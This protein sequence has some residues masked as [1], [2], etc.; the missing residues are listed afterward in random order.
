MNKYYSFDQISCITNED[1]Y[2]M[3]YDVSAEHN[4]I[5]L[6]SALLCS[7]DTY[8]DLMDK[9]NAHNTILFL[10]AMPTELGTGDVASNFRFKHDINKNNLVTERWLNVFREYKKNKNKNPVVITTVGRED[11]YM[12][13]KLLDDGTVNIVNNKNDDYIFQ[14]ETE[15]IKKFLNVFSITSEH[16]KKMRISSAG[17]RYNTYMADMI[18]FMNI[19][20]YKY[21]QDMFYKS[22]MESYIVTP[23]CKIKKSGYYNGKLEPM[24]QPLVING[25]EWIPNEGFNYLYFRY[26]EGNTETQQIFYKLK[27]GIMN[28]VYYQIFQALMPEENGTKE[29]IRNYL[30]GIVYNRLSDFWVNDIDDSFTILMLINAY[31]YC[32]LNDNDTLILERFEN[33]AEPWFKEM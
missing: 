15:I 5:E 10:P 13:F 16:M 21:H 1:F 28:I 14:E 31:K 25:K 4:I 24:L 18:G 20:N 33:I 22:S 30:S 27:P 32:E 12:T 23:E 29:M 6:A 3:E 9:L 8:G 2:S 11:R 19:L 17:A 7:D 26:Q